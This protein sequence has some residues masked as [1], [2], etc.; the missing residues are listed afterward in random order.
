MNAKTILLEALDAR[1]GKFRA[2][3]KLCREEFSE[4][5]VHDLRVAS[6][7]L[8]AFFDLLRSVVLHKR[9]QK[10]RRTLKDQLDDLDDLRDTQVLLADISESLHELP[11][12]EFFKIQLQAE[13]KKLLKHARKAIKSRDFDR[14]KTRVEKMRAII[15]AL[16]D[17]R[18]ASQLLSA[19]DEIHARMMAAHSTMSPE[20]I[21]GIHK[22][23]IAFK[24]FRYAVEV[25][26]PLLSNYPPGHLERM[27]EYQSKMGDIQDMD[28]A[29]QRLEEIERPA[30]YES[31]VHYFRSR[32]GA[33]VSSFVEDSA[34]AFVFWR[35]APDQSFPWEKNQP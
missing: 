20:N 10:I 18:L 17:E 28:T 6:R 35:S 34:E 14:L 13:E 2:E 19:G 25:I 30:E 12:L 33:A 32:L 1:W 29:L 16:P 24:R 26:H 31:V 15:E 8:L 27:H 9:I 4:E 22:L 7:R 3:L 11:H 5:A 23:R 21:P